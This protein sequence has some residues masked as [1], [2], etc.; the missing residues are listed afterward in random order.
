MTLVRLSS[1]AAGV[2]VLL[3]FAAVSV[4]ASTGRSATT[5][6]AR[7]DTS[8]ED[9]RAYTKYKG[10]NKQY[11]YDKKKYFKKE[12]KCVTPEIK[13]FVNNTLPFIEISQ[14]E[15]CSTKNF[16]KGKN[17]CC[18]PQATCVETVDYKFKL[19]STNGGSYN[20]FDHE[21]CPRTNESPEPVSPFVPKDGFCCLADG[22]D[23][24]GIVNKECKV[25]DSQF[26]FPFTAL[27]AF[28]SNA[29]LCCGGISSSYFNIRFTNG[30]SI[31]WGQVFGIL[32]EAMDPEDFATFQHAVL[33]MTNA[34]E[35]LDMGEVQG[36]EVDNP[37][38]RGVIDTIITSL[39][40]LLGN[41][42][43][44]QSG[45]IPLTL[46]VLT[47]E[48]FQTCGQPLLLGLSVP[49]DDLPESIGRSRLTLPLFRYSCPAAVHPGNGGYY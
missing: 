2:V 5:A 19:E 4:D 23:I 45:P 42:T 3:A 38:L 21:V 39:E 35:V 7:P 16:V 46:N 10:Y 14:P 18:D 26:V 44:F 34:N 17:D 28:N 6:T 11:K 31:N 8:A 1:V 33:M 20:G 30:D 40:L 12:D 43:C 36:H 47:I 48:F 24:S 9:S 32:S 25:F 49:I 22:T 15:P 13:V 27:Q 37:S 41:K 29:C